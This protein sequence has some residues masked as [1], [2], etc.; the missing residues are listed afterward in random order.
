LSGGDHGSEVPGLANLRRDF[1]TFTKQAPHEN[2]APRNWPD[3]P[4]RFLL[5]RDLQAARLTLRGHEIHLSSQKTPRRGDC[6]SLSVSEP[7][8]RA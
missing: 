7:A 6:G 2:V 1:D 5:P 3:Y 4:H 8:H